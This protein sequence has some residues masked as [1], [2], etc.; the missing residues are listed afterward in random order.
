M[1]M[2]LIRSLDRGGMMLAKDLNEVSVWGSY[3]T[4][5]WRLP[6][7]IKGEHAGEKTLS[8]QFSELYKRSSNDLRGDLET[9]F[10]ERR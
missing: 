4:L 8:S 10:K 5:N 3:Q 1:E 2:G 9:L 7:D 6:P